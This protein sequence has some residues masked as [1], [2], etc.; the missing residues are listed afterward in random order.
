MLSFPFRFNAD[1]SAATVE[2]A[3]DA[4]IAEQINAFIQTIRGERPMAL[5]YGGIDPVFDNDFD[6]GMI[7]AGLAE[8][9]PEASIKSISQTWSGDNTLDVIVE[10]ERA[11]S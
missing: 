4:A 5:G 3:S 6:E 8:F 7:V 2:D 1:G 10:F 11:Q 9:C